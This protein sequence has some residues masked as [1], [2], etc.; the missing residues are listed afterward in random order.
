[1][2]TLSLT[3]F[4]IYF[5]WACLGQLYAITKQQFKH[6]S[7]IKTYGGFKKSIWILENWKRVLST[8]IAIIIGVIFFDAVPGIALNPLT[9]FLAGFFADQ[10]ADAIINKKK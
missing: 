10:N 9:A 5:G 6:S 3:E 2:I 1:M 4:F 8:I 7:P